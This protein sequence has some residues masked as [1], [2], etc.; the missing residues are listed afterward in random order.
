VEHCHDLGL[1]VVESRLAGTDPEAIKTLRQKVEGYQMRLILDVGY[2]R[3]EAG[4]A[5]F[6]ASVKAAKECGAISLH[7]AM[8][9]RPLRGHELAR[10]VPAELRT[11]P[12]IDRAG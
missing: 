12:E 9:G 8:T 7:A 6:D 11:L 5:A 2:P 4:V 3:D 1:G 10:G